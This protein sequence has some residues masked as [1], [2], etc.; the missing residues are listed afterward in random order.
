MENNL[1]IEFKK[2]DSKLKHLFDLDNSFY[3]K[4]GD[5][6]FL[7]GPNGIGKTT[8]LLNLANVKRN[9][10]FTYALDSNKLKGR[11]LKSFLQRT[12]LI[13]QNPKAQLLGQIIR[14]ELMLNHQMNSLKQ[15]EIFSF[16]KYLKLDNSILDKNSWELSF[17]QMRKILLLDVLLSDNDF[18]LLDEPSN[19]LDYESQLEFFNLIKKIA[20]EKYVLIIS[21]DSNIVNQFASRVL[22]IK[23]KQVIEVNKNKMTNLLGYNWESMYESINKELTKKEK[24]IFEQIWTS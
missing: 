20:R 18:L 10:K 24:E 16:I 1:N 13:F 14:E 7:I 6:N 19:N 12:H 3:L 11:K 4:K 23:D 5:I 22:T 17:G 21:H 8:L 15:Q 2:L 9:I